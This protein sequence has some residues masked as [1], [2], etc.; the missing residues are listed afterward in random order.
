MGLALRLHQAGDRHQFPGAFQAEALRLGLEVQGLVLLGGT[1][2]HLFE[3]VL[4]LLP[5]GDGV[6]GGEEEPFERVLH[7]RVVH[8]PVGQS[9]RLPPGLGDLGRGALRDLQARVDQLVDG[10]VALALGDDQVVAALRA[11]HQFDRAR[12]RHLLLERVDAVLDALAV[13]V[14][15]LGRDEGVDAL[16]HAHLLEHLTDGVAAGALG[17]GDG[18]LL[19]V[20][21]PREVRGAAE[22]IL[23]ELVAEVAHTGQSAAEDGDDHQTGQSAAPLL[24]L[25][26]APA[27]AASAPV[28]RFAVAAVV[29]VTAVPVVV[30]AREERV[31]A[32]VGSRVPVGL[33]LGLGFRLGPPPGRGLGRRVGLGVP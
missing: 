28:A 19:A 20:A 27:L 6:A 22:T 3:H 25:A 18:D 29:A 26:A 31:L 9:E 17:D 5:L 21:G 4:R 7:V 8:G 23:I 30:A 32:L 11:E 12:G 33:R 2:H 1:S 24:L 15:R 13:R 14:G 10:R 16:D